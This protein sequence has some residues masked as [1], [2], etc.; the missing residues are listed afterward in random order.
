M[1]FCKTKQQ[2]AAISIE[3]VFQD[4]GFLLP[5]QIIVQRVK[6]GIR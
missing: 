3:L 4:K 6:L 2:I 1:F 5:L